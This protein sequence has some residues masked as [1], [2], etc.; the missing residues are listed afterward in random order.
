MSQL[1]SPM[2][3][4]FSF[5]MCAKDAGATVAR[6]IG[7]L[8]PFAAQSELCF[9]DDGS[10]DDT[11]EIAL[12]KSEELGMAL[13]SRR[14]DVNVGVPAARNIA[15][16]MAAG[17]WLI[18]FDADDE[19]LPERINSVI[20]PI[21]VSDVVGGWAYESVGGEVTGRVM[22]YPPADDREIKA[23]LLT[24]WLNPMIDPTTCI[25]RKMFEQLGGYTEDPK[26]RHVQ[27][28]EFWHRAA[29][30][31]ARFANVQRPLIKYSL[32]PSGVTQ[33]KKQEMIQRHGEL[34][35][36]YQSQVRRRMRPLWR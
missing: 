27:D 1:A 2:S 30:A 33:T 13:S 20:L 10:S 36:M 14:L 18:I 8:Q 3:V 5:I 35:R 4:K 31:G 23:M 6:A 34:M 29:S 19:C 12:R 21:E 24:S 11:Y 22:D 15:A 16:S 25:R 7:S 26:W 17:D 9:V 28:L 32:N